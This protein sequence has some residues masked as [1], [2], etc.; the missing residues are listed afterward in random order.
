MG[1]PLDYEPRK[2]PGEGAETLPFW[3]GVTL[4]MGVS[5]LFCAG[6]IVYVMD[7]LAHVLYPYPMLIIVVAEAARVRA[8][9]ALLWAVFLVAA[10]QY[11]L[12]GGIIGYS[13]MKGQMTMYWTLAVLGICH[14]IAMIVA[15]SLW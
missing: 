5:P 12:Y 8:D 13:A 2:R 4:G 9:N 1:E 15:I 7:G 6:A 3:V 10:V 11:P 14:G